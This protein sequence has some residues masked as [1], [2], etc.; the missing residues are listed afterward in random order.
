MVQ[1]G[2]CIARLNELAP[3]LPICPGKHPPYVPAGGGALQ[4]TFMQVVSHTWEGR[5]FLEGKFSAPP[6]F[7][8]L[9]TISCRKF[10]QPLTSGNSACEISSCMRAQR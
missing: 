10:R 9:W 2:N 3:H 5:I 7:G 1:G 6:N 4:K 8:A